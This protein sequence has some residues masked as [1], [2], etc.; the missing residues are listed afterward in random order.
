MNLGTAVGDLPEHVAENRRRLTAHLPSEPKW[1]RQVH[2]NV[3]VNADQISRPPEAD[4]AYAST[5]NTVCAVTVAD[6]LPVLFCS[7]DGTTVA[8]AHAGW[9]GLCSGV[10]ERTIDALNVPASR[11]LAYLGPAIGPDAFEVGE[12]VYDAFVTHDAGA[13]AAFRPHF[14]RKWFADLFELARMRLLRKGVS[15]IHGG[16]DCTVS[17]PMRFFSHR[18]DKVSGRMAALIW[19]S[20]G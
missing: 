12:D 1:L 18:R 14:S 15:S 19:R 6:C 9:R 7:R 13:M 8:V 2:G 5:A 11:L 10:L 17:D 3:V 20:A 4:A 16:N